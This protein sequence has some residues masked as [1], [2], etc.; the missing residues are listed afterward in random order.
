MEEERDPESSGQPSKLFI[1]Q[2]PREATEE[3][4][5]GMF[6]RFGPIRELTIMRDNAT[7]VS[8]GLCMGFIGVL[9]DG[10]GGWSRSRFLEGWSGVGEWSIYYNIDMYI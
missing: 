4:L 6:E 10:L 5:Q 7:G 9:C 2:I 8:K 3:D 1:G